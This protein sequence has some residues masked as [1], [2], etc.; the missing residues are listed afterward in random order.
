M[1]RS[2]RARDGKRSPEIRG[3]SLPLPFPPGART[4]VI[5]HTA[6]VHDE[7]VTG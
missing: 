4:L 3:S 2:G 7:D 5:V 6:L 1:K